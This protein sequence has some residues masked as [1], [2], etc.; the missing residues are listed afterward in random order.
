[1]GTNHDASVQ[2]QVM[3]KRETQSA[4]KIKQTPYSI[5]VVIEC[6]GYREFSIKVDLTWKNQ[7]YLLLLVFLIDFIYVFFFFQFAV[8]Q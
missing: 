8:F 5:D 4:R 7:L 6:D 2:L 1:M 3:I